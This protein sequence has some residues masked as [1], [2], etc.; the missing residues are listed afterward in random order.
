[1]YKDPSKDSGSCGPQRSECSHSSILF[2]VLIEVCWIILVCL[3]CIHSWHT[4]VRSPFACNA[5][6]GSIVQLLLLLPFAERDFTS[7]V[8]CSESF[9]LRCLKSFRL[10]CLKSL[11]DSLVALYNSFA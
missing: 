5:V 7:E 3:L 9:R 11:T 10:R 8:R 4:F 2:M 1:M 6:R